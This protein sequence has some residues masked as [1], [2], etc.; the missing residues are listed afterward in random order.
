L[1]AE[2]ER[3]KEENDEFNT[4][5]K[6]QDELNEQLQADNAELVEALRDIH[7]TAKYEASV[8][9]IYQIESLL[10]KHSPE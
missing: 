10:S 8:S 2:N 9:L 7:K 6:I 1:K 4:A 5:Y 3:L